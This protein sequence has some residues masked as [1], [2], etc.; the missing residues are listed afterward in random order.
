LKVTLVISQQRYE[1]MQ[2][3][4]IDL[5]SS[6]SIFPSDELY[7]SFTTHYL[8]PAI[9][10]LAVAINRDVMWKPTNH[11]LLGLTRSKKKAVRM[12]ALYALKALFEEV[13]TTVADMDKL[14][15]Y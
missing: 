8:I 2:P 13:C 7:L 11:S 6:R 3:H 5:I 14:T 1:V 15:K 12:T 10:K 9:T 4:L